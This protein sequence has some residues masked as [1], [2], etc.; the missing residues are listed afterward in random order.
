MR[1]E[2]LTKLINHYGFTHGAEI[3]V[4]C[5]TGFL[6]P[7]LAK[8]PGLHML[9]VDPWELHPSFTTWFPSEE[10]YKSAMRVVKKY[11]PRVSVIRKL[12]HLAAEDVPDGSLDFVYI[13][14]THTYA[15]ICQDV[16]CWYPKVKD[17]GIICGHD[18]EY[19]N[20]AGG[21]IR[22]INE[23]G[24]IIKILPQDHCL[25]AA[26]EA[27]KFLKEDKGVYRGGIA[28]MKG[29]TWFAWKLACKPAFGGKDGD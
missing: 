13:D 15:A 25:D 10:H 17:D 29:V 28:D 12:S 6:E 23:M 20:E 16:K 5:G 11:K 2:T 21:H 9:A 1:I 27:F 7:M 3:G 19:C 8:N 22:G 14:A 18:Y 24:R 26:E 4:A